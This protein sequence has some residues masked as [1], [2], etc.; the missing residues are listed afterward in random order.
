MKFVRLTFR[1]FVASP[2]EIPRGAA[3]RRLA[4]IAAALWA[5]AAVSTQAQTGPFSPSDWPPTINTNVTVDYVIIDPN[6]VFNTPAAWNANLIL[7]NGGDEAYSGITLN[8]L[9]GDQATSTFIN[10][11]DP[12]YTMFANV[13]VIDILLQVYGNS[14]LYNADGSAKGVG[15][16][17]GELNYLTQPSAGTVPPGANNAVWNWMLFTVTNAVD[18]KTGFRYVGDTSYPQQT[19]GQYGGVNSGTLRLAGIGAG[20]TVRAVALGPQGAFGTSNQVN[21]FTPPVTCP[22]EPPVNLTYVDFNLE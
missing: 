20:L 8:G 19:G 11:A 22:A 13:P 4:W 7:A 2:I 18:S 15:F 9:Y 5:L 10:I 12:N 17:E 6:A 1:K 16:L 3:R 21:V 14:S